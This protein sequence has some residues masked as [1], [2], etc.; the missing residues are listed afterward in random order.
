MKQELERKKQ[1]LHA[2]TDENSLLQ[3]SLRSTQDQLASALDDNQALT[4]A[5][6]RLK[7]NII[8]IRDSFQEDHIQSERLAQMERD[9][10][11][12]KN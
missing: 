12:Q 7:Q 6:D 11:S 3:T 4:A 1:Q 2:L 9:L 8:Q 5:T 10:Q